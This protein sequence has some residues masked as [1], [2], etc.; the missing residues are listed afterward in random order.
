MQLQAQGLSEPDLVK[1]LRDEGVSAEEINDALSQARIKQAVSQEQQEPV[2]QFQGM[3]QSMMEQPATEPVAEPQQYYPQEQQVYQD[4]NQG[5]YQ[6]PAVDTETIS[7][8]ADQVVQEKFAEFN[9]KT[10]DLVSFRNEVKDKLKDLDERLKR[11]EGSLDNIQRAVIGKIGE[12][13]ENMAFVQ[14]DLTNIHDTM[15][16]MMNPLIDNYRELKKISGG[17]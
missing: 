7:E 3:E 8:I 9:K 6:Q 13:G 12:Y 10:G 2:E 4:P 17:K 16:K 1:R 15:S 14:K 11:I 5:Y